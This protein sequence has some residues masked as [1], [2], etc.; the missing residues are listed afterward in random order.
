MI[1]FREG[2]RWVQDYIKIKIVTVSVH[3]NNKKAPQ[4]V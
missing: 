2:N 1:D 4:S 3:E